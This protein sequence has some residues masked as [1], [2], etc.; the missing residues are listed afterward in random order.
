MPELTAKQIKKIQEEAAVASAKN[1]A[2]RKKNI[3]KARQETEDRNS[4][5]FMREGATW[6][7]QEVKKAGVH[8][9][10]VRTRAGDGLPRGPRG[11]RFDSGKGLERMR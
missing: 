3:E 5:F 4:Q 1:M 8:S 7:K 10:G 2:E 6:T 9:R 11:G